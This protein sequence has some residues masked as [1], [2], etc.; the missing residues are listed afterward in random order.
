MKTQ[1]QINK[2]SA[3]LHLENFYAVWRK[4]GNSAPSFRHGT[5]EEA[6]K[7]A[8]RLA[9]KTEDPYFILKTIGVVKPVELPVE[10]EEY[11]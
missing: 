7:E 6:I 8:N 10:Y 4:S 3:N 5:K 9:R 1:E 2:E 11:E